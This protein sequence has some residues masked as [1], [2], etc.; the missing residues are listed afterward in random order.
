[1]IGA[2]GGTASPGTDFVRSSGIARVPALQRQFTL[3]VVILDDE[4]LEDLETVAIV[5][6]WAAGSPQTWL[7][8][9]DV[10]AQG[11]IKDDEQDGQEPVVSVGS[12][13]EAV[14]GAPLEFT[15]S[16]DVPSNQ[17]VTVAVAT[18]QMVTG[19]AAVKGRDYVN[20]TGLVTFGPGDEQKT[21]SV[22]TL[23]DSE[24]EGHE[25][26]QL[27]LLA[28]PRP[29]GATLDPDARIAIGT[30]LDDDCVAVASIG[31][32]DSPPA[33]EFRSHS[34]AG[35]RLG[36]GS[37]GTEVHFEVVPEY[38]MC[39]T[40]YIQAEAL[41]V[42]AT[43][44]DFTADSALDN[45]AIPPDGVGRFS[46]LAVADA[47]SE[48]DETFEVVVHWHP[49]SMPPHFYDPVGGPVFTT[50]ATII[51]ASSL[52]TITA[53]A[54]VVLEGGT[55]V[56][57]VSID[58]ASDRLVSVDYA[59][60]DGTAESPAD[61]EH[62]QG[63][64]RFWPGGDLTEQVMVR[65]VADFELEDT[66]DFLLDLSDPVNATLSDDPL[67]VGEMI[68]RAEI[69]DLEAS[70]R[71][72]GVNV[73]AAPRALDVSWTAP[74]SPDG[75]TGY[76]VR[77]EPAPDEIFSAPP[78]EVRVSDTSTSVR[79]GDLVADVT[80]VVVVMAEYQGGHTAPAPPST[81]TPT[82][83]S[84]PPGGPQ[85]ATFE[86][87]PGARPA[88]QAR[89]D[90][91]VAVR[92]SWTAPPPSDGV[93][94]T[95]LQWRA[96][97]ASYVDA[98]RSA[99]GAS[100]AGVDEF[101]LGSVYDLRLRH[102]SVDGPGPW[103]EGT[104][105]VIAFAPDPP[106]LVRV[107]ASDASVSPVWVAPAFDGGSAV[108]AYV[109][110]YREIS[111]DP[112]SAI[113][114]DA[115]ANT[116]RVTGL[117]NGHSYE[118]R[119]LA[120]NAAGTSLPSRTVTAEPLAL[121][122]APANVAMTG[123][124]DRVLVEWDPP[125]DGGEGDGEGDIVGY[126]VEYRTSSTPFILA[127]PWLDVPV[128]GTRTVT[129]TGLTL[130]DS[131]DVRVRARNNSAADSGE[132]PGVGPWSVTVSGGPSTEP[133]EPRALVLR[134]LDN[135]M[136]VSWQAPRYDGES[137]ITG[138]D[139]QY[140]LDA[141]P[142]GQWIEVVSNHGT[143]AISITGLVN[144]TS[145][146]VRVRARNG[147]GEDSG[148]GPGVG[149]WTVPVTGAPST[150]P[151]EPLNVVLTPFHRQLDA[152]WHAPAS[153][154]ESSITAYQVEY[155][156]PT[157]GFRRFHA[158][159]LSAT[160]R[161]LRN[162][163]SY[164][165]R[166][167]A[168][169]GSDEDGGDGR[170]VGPWSSPVWGTPDASVPSEPLNVRFRYA[171]HQ[172]IAEW[173][174]PE[175]DSRATVASYQMEW[176]GLKE[177]YDD[178]YTGA[179]TRGGD[180]DR[181]CRRLELTD[182]SWYWKQIAPGQFIAEYSKTRAHV[183]GLCCI[184]NYGVYTPHLKTPEYEVRVRAVNVA[185]PGPWSI[186]VMGGRSPGPVGGLTAQVTAAPA[187]A[188]SVLLQWTAP[189]DDGGLPIGRC[190][191]D[192][193]SILCGYSV[194]WKASSELWGDAQERNVPATETSTLI[195][196][197]ELGQTYDFEVAALNRAG[198]GGSRELAETPILAPAT[199]S[200]VRVVAGDS[201]LT[202]EWKLSATDAQP[203]AASILRWRVE[204]G[205]DA[206]WTVVT[207]DG[208]D[209]TA[210]T[211]GNLS[212]GTVYEVQVAASNSS[213]TSDWTAAASGEP[214]EA[215][216][217]PQNLHGAGWRDQM[218]IAWDW[219][220][221]EDYP[222]DGFLIRWRRSTESTFAPADQATLGASARDH[223]VHLFGRHEL[224]QQIFLYNDLNRAYVVEVTALN[225]V[226]HLGTATVS[227]VVNLPGKFLSDEVFPPYD[228]NHPWIRTTFEKIPF[229]VQFTA[230]GDMASLNI[231][232]TQGHG[233]FFYN[234]V[235]YMDFR[236]N[237]WDTLREDPAATDANH[238]LVHEIAHAMTLDRDN[239][240][241][242]LA[243]LGLYHLIWIDGDDSCLV[244]EIL[245]ETI[246]VHVVP[247]AVSDYYRL[248][249]AV[250]AAPTPEAAAVTASALAG[251]IPQWFDDRYEL[252]GG[253]MDMEKLWAD[254]ADP[255]LLAQD[256]DT[257]RTLFNEPLA[258]VFQ[259]FFGGVCSD[260]EAW[261]SFG[262]LINN[263][264]NDDDRVT[265]N[266]W[267]DGGCESHRPTDVSIV[268]QSNSLEVTWEPPLWTKRPDAGMYSVQWTGPG[269]TYS[270]ERTVLVRN[271]NTSATIE[272]LSSN[273]TY[274][275]RLALVG[276][277]NPGVLYGWDPIKRYVEFEAT[278]G[279]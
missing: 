89:P 75:L 181:R 10:S 272:Q 223:A 250:G 27:R 137:A 93:I 146:Q 64:L 6:R 87:H 212:N 60:S 125:V 3:N 57:D 8:L 217:A 169:N 157:S 224:V 262:R 195:E 105:L 42:S 106:T 14:E 32:G 204:G 222:I 176:R 171:G 22:R 215:S 278:T 207:H 270:G 147:S 144:G 92:V 151:T 21:V 63:V 148:S 174:P 161:G 210:Q 189:A 90:L 139:V 40:V 133:T 246:S 271:G 150:L 128:T 5:V 18:H 132:G 16:L 99:L 249:D 113:E 182:D 267:I 238:A 78:Q 209:R 23:H 97:G 192:T 178:F 244:H 239:M 108:T 158:A 160:I 118:L 39:E 119:V 11:I 12:P 194:R 241:V 177:G 265:A 218:R 200:D 259:E 268:S 58:A 211:I 279:P 153:D 45:I 225:G 88:A 123:Y 20:W 240:T 15:V 261:E 233:W 173:D 185:G 50:T 46:V 149:E 168:L 38:R 62:E 152:Q 28:S 220:D 86:V 74:A 79:V 122:S 31:A 264:P 124:R 25:S 260:H 48:T 116:V 163:E 100:P 59:T 55:A 91:P 208:F 73:T 47:L 213:G 36:L 273:T 164:Q 276:S 121:P 140:R 120:R 234:I 129:I 94:L 52:P 203:V 228:A 214:L 191:P 53:T 235:E 172:L 85:G 242:P 136:D 44:S 156:N 251:Q 49:D 247:D 199:P 159:G 41:P 30:I 274:T 19:D 186:P 111:S 83:L 143:L 275:V 7:D 80:Y 109:V 82:A 180:F 112:W 252:A 142:P 65:T 68:V 56:F 29:Q 269:E 98:N 219:T 127:G 230:G 77:V 243:V 193:V 184:A 37:E 226:T 206:D 198:R 201:R 2:P 26:L 13:V 170:G 257:Q 96:E 131:Y 154:G 253:S 229:G 130:G 175:H 162:G 102:W 24:I 54:P 196:N 227:A 255:D 61:Y 258:L 104:G 266:P 33:L 81:G 66:E 179:C 245:A 69:L 138:Y 101:D 167:R 197:L 190:D 117:V 237:A 134:S 221:S 43:A 231:T 183:G 67:S 95:E 155:G 72:T 141:A 254:L 165:V 107:D 1:M 9:G 51:D 103:V 256:P 35:E 145:Y 205:T 188:A 248:C 17:T 263:N 232:N 71:P 76:V 126:D 216:D 166:V 202:V 115:P 84:T 277:G 34:S 70:R 135:R 114:V 236:R 110:E 4:D 187:Q